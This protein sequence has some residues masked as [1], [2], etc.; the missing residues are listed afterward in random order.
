MNFFSLQLPNQKKA[1]GISYTVKVVKTAFFSWV[2]DNMEFGKVTKNVLRTIG[3]PDATL[4]KLL[5]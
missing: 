4:L 3:M 5:L 1:T 2:T